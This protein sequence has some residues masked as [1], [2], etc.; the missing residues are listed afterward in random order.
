PRFTCRIS[1]APRPHLLSTAYSSPLHPTISRPLQ[2]LPRYQPP[3]SS[4]LYP[5]CQ[6]LSC[7]S[8]AQA[9]TSTLIRTSPASLSSPP[10]ITPRT[11]SSPPHQP[12]PERCLS[13]AHY[14]SSSTEFVLRDQEFRFALRQRLLLPP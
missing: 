6:P 11:S 4:P 12:L 8:P 5:L 3:D 14:L 1:P 13:L 7:H 9:T 10:Q 2:A